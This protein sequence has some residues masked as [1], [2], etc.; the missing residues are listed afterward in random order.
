[1]CS[2]VASSST[3][4]P[5]TLFYA[6]STAAGSSSGNSATS[7]TSGNSASSAS[8]ATS[9]SELRD[10]RPSSPLHMTASSYRDA[11]LRSPGKRETRKMTV[12]IARVRDHFNIVS[13]GAPQEEITSTLF[14]RVFLKKPRGLS[15][16]PCRS[17]IRG[18]PEPQ[19]DQNVPKTIVFYGVFLSCIR[20]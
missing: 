9:L 16:R 12:T 14:L 6:T 4:A 5:S 19:E 10:L 15:H 13:Q 20:A 11:S 2:K 1:M 17:I 3:S 18:G 8:S 7:A